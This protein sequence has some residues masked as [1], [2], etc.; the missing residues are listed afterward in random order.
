MAKIQP[1]VEF[2]NSFDAPEN[3][4][5]I[6]DFLK[7]DLTDRMH[8]SLKALVEENLETL[9]RSEKKFK[10]LEKHAHKI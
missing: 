1:L 2:V 8:A 6:L 9:E 5:R 7:D 4:K 10:K 3:L